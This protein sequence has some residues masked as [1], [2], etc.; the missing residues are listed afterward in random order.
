MALHRALPLSLPKSAAAEIEREVGLA[1]TIMADGSL[2]LDK[3]PV[4]LDALA[5][6]LRARAGLTQDMESG[7]EAEPGEPFVQVFAEDSLSYQDLYRVLD[8]IKLS[9]VHKVS[10]QAGAA[11]EAQGGGQ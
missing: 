1:L 4:R 3:E 9:G 11:D 7:G 5:E 2:Y 8:Q 10:L 6:I